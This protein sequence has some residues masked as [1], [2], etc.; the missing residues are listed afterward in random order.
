[1]QIGM[2]ADDCTLFR[3]IGTESDIEVLQMDLHELYDWS[4]K[5]QL[6]LN[7]LKN[8]SNCWRKFRNEQLDGSVLH[9]IA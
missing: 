7:L 2:F 6:H 9:G 4:Q 5:W 3:E 8:M 1:M